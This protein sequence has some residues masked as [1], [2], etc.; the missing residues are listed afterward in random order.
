MVL[1][2]WVSR[3]ELTWNVQGTECD[4]TRWGRGLG[5]GLPRTRLNAWQELALERA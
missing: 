5:G 1:L 3:E 2:V 4:V